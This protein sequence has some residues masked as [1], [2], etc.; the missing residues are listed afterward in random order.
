M[1][2]DH[3]FTSQKLDATGLYYYNARYYDP[4]IGQFIS[5]D[6]LVP[7]ATNLFDYNRYMYSRGNPVKY[8]DPTGHCATLDNGDPDW[9]G[10]GDCWGL[11]YSIYG[12]GLAGV[13]GFAQDWRISPDQWLKDIATASYATA[14]YLNPFYAQ[15]DSEWR[16]SVGLTAYTPNEA[17]PVPSFVE[18]FDKMYAE[19]LTLCARKIGGACGV[20]TGL[21]GQAFILGGRFSLDG[22]VDQNGNRMYYFTPAL[23]VQISAKPLGVSGSNSYIF[24]PGASAND[25]KGLGGSAGASIAIV[26][27]LAVD[28]VFTIADT[29]PKPLGVSVGYQTGWNVEGHIMGSYSFVLYDPQGR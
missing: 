26:R 29:G 17:P 12:Y 25:F 16:G 8:T 23:G 18:E 11:A 22:Y 5:P 13:N 10:D 28:A 20:S 3:K 2:T 19:M 1:V 27:G 6:T 15:Y 24:A 9:E 14:E 4:E 21:N 7:Q